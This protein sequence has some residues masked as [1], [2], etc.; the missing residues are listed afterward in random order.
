LPPTAHASHWLSG[1][2]LGLVLGGTALSAT[3]SMRPEIEPWAAHCAGNPG[4]DACL[5]FW[6]LSH[7]LKQQAERTNQLS[8]YTSLLALEAVVTL[9]K[10]GDADAT[11]LNVTLQDVEATCP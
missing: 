8:C 4:G 7:R 5:Q 9:A 3:A 1:V 11:R 6:P 2:A 10:L